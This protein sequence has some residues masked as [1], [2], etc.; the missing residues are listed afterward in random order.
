MEL[1]INSI[2]KPYQDDPAL[3][4]RQASGWKTKNGYLNEAKQ[5]ARCLVENQRLRGEN[6]ALEAVVK[7]APDLTLQEHDTVWKKATRNMKNRRVVGVWVREPS[8]S[9]R[10]HYHLLLVSPELPRVAG[11][12]IKQAIPKA[13]RSRAVVHVDSV[14]DQ[15]A[16]CYYVCKAKLPYI[17][18][19]TGKYYR[20]RWA[21]K[22]LLFF[23]EITLQKYGSIGR[24]WHTP[25]REIWK[26]IIGEERRLSQYRSEVYH[27]AQMLHRLVGVEVSLNRIVRNLCW[28]AAR[29][30]ER[31][32]G[33][34][35]GVVV[36]EQPSHHGK[37]VVRD[38]VP[39]GPFVH[40]H[41]PADAVADQGCRTP[42]VTS[43]SP[44]VCE[45]GE[46][47]VDLLAVRAVHP[48][49][50]CADLVRAVPLEQ[51]KEAG[52]GL[53]AVVDHAGIYAR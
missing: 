21:G 31:E 48:A 41:L 5:L 26:Q 10:V 11:D 4:H 23:R 38:F 53:R 50:E 40:A 28:T 6:Y 30:V 17:D 20:D 2:Q 39:V 27:E 3:G 33:V 8:R 51:P 14:R 24:F 12:T 35:V 32:E 47:A 46:E 44:L 52:V 25:K 36:Y 49:V 22:R 7:F 1:T 37:V 45:P 13:Y 19:E 15:F 16:M 42:I 9:G 29:A 34:E 18:P 43:V